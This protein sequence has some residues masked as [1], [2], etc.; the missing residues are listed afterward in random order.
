MQG[1]QPCISYAAFPA[2]PANLTAALS[3][4]QLLLQLLTALGFDDL[5]L[6]AGL[7]VQLFWIS[8]PKK[9]V[10]F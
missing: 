4:P 1:S 3:V 5:L 7:P 10:H 6:L 8:D 9:E 2:V